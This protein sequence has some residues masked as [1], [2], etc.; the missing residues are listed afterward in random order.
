MAP[1]FWRKQITCPH[2]EASFETVKLFSNAV[3][4]EER[5]IF[6]RPT[7]RP[8]NPL[9]FYLTTCPK[10]YYT[11]LEKDFLELFLILESESQKQL[12]QVLLKAVQTFQVNLDENRTIDDAILQHSLAVLT[13]SVKGDAFQ[14]AQLYLKMGWFYIE[15]ERLEDVKIAYS[16]AIKL[17]GQAFLK[18]RSPAEADGVLFFLGALHI[19]LNQKKEGFKWLEKLIQERRGSNSPYYVAAKKLWEEVRTGL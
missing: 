17:F 15:K 6:F 10:C 14:Q 7:Y 11:A 19:F 5:D 1:K 2:C 13:Y 12:S 18:Q 4:L 8:P 9:F 16:K 3:H